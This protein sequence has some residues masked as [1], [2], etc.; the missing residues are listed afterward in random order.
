V[1]INTS[2]LPNVDMSMVKSDCVFR[3]DEQKTVIQSISVQQY[4]LL[5][6]LEQAMVN[7]SALVGLRYANKQDEILM[8]VHFAQNEGSFDYTRSAKSQ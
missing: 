6:G 1:K 3:I 5:I 8:A 7:L 2:L 4:S